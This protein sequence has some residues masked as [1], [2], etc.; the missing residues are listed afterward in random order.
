M[1]GPARLRGGEPLPADA[2]GQFRWQFVCSFRESR[3]H[4][5]PTT[6]TM[7]RKVRGCPRQSSTGVASHARGCSVAP[8]ERMVPRTDIVA[9]EI[10]HMSFGHTNVEFDASLPPIKSER[11]SGS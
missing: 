9:A 3:V 6:S 8:K 11:D 2:Q 1:A 7:F 10:L 5:S 4:A